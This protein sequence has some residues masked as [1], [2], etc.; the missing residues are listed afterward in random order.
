MLIQTIYMILIFELTFN[1]TETAFGDHIL[2]KGHIHK[3]G[4]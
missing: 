1:F 2:T 3:T 4:G